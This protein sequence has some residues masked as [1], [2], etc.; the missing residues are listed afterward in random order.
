LNVA[1]FERFNVPARPAAWTAATQT[2]RDVGGGCD[3]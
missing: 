3:R 1:T 2:G